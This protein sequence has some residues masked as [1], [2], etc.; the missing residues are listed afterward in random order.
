M[1]A[2]QFLYHNVAVRYR[3]T[4]T[5]AFQSKLIGLDPANEQAI[6]DVTLVGTTEKYANQLTNFIQQRMQLEFWVDDLDAEFTLRQI[7][8]YIKPIASGYPQ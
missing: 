7:Q 3:V 5:G 6:T 4:G 8:F 1:A 2:G